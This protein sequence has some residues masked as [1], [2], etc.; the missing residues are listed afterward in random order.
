MPQV[1]HY[2]TH[3]RLEFQLRP[4]RL[5]AH[6]GGPAPA[7]V[8]LT[9]A[10]VAARLDQ[11]LGLPAL[12]Q[13]LVPGDH[14]VVAVEPDV[15][16]SGELIEGVVAYLRRHGVGPECLTV[17]RASEAVECPPADADRFQLETHD[18]ARHGGLCYVAASRKGRPIYL[19]RALVE[20]DVVLS[21]GVARGGPWLGYPEPAGGLYPTFSDAATLRRY[22]NPRLGSGDET[23]LRRAQR[24]IEGVDWL[25][26]TRFAIEAVPGPDGG[27]LDWH[28]GEAVAVS[29]RARAA[30]E[31]AWLHTIP[32]RAAVVVVALSAAP[33]AQTWHAVGHALDVG[34]RAVD[35]DG[36]IVVL[37]ELADPPGPAVDR[38]G[39]SENARDAF[40]RIDAERQADTLDAAAVLRATQN[41]R[42]F[43]LSQLADEVV[44]PLG[45]AP[46]SEAG[47]AARLAERAGSCLLVAQAEQIALR[48]AG[49]SLVET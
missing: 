6:C 9:A 48:V 47:D 34:L 26:G 13:A 2:G 28:A 44:E 21:I 19:N 30:W 3:G 25:A 43:F 18:P 24:E 29:Q 46:L 31:A 37:S 10:A 32:R 35:D 5:V 22:R 42:V 20:A 39:R 38:L 8:A 41:A 23:L 27:L 17:L 15:P 14:V 11:P 4:E 7:D 36:A 1:L 45:L 40:L 49:E 33:G 12:A 16:R